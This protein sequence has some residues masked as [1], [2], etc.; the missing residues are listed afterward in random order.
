M[1]LGPADDGTA[2]R[3]VSEAAA[4]AGLEPVTGNGVDE[5]LAGIA[6]DRDGV[7]LAAAM[8]DA[9][10]AF[11]R[12]RC[13]DAV[14]AAKTAIGLAAERQAAGLPV[15]ELT[16]AWAYVL[17]CA[18]KNGDANAATLAANRLRALGGSSDIDARLMARYPEI[19]AVSNRE[20]VDVEVV[21]EVPGATVYVDFVPARGTHLVLPAGEHVIAAAAGTRRGYVAGPAV[22][23]QKSV[24]IPMPDQAGSNGALA[25]RVASWH[26][27]VPAPAELA[28]VLK[29]VRA[30]VALV[31]HDDVVEAWGHARLADPVHRLGGAAGTRP[32]ADVDKLAALVA[33]HVE[34]WNDHAPDPDQP[35]L[36]EDVRTRAAKKLAEE[37]EPTR[38]WVYATIG[39]ALLAGAVV[40]YAHESASDTQRVELHYP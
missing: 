39:G 14:K 16:H 31:R 24:A 4:Q 2:R 25:A 29:A 15:P 27:K 28:A 9:E 30:R 6:V 17:L 36:V 18:D 1:D 10:H 40:I 35:L 32:L 21:P 13:D 23:A 11:G 38:W 12:L 20:L 37:Q 8:Q 5:A 7:L 34:A 3:I 33:D 26:G 19:D 22:P